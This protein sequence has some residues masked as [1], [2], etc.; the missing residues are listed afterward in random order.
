LRYRFNELHLA[1]RREEPPLSFRDRMIK[2]LQLVVQSHGVQLV[3]GRG[4]AKSNLMEGEDSI[5]RSDV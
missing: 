3:G 2:F 1:T 5:K 4:E